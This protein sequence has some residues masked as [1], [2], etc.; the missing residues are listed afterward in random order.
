MK[1]Y[2][3]LFLALLGILGVG[4][5]C[6]SPSSSPVQA[7]VPKAPQNAPKAAEAGQIQGGFTNAFQGELKVVGQI[8]TEEFAKRYPNSAKY[9]DA[10]PWDPTTAQYYDHLQLDPNDP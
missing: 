5:Y 6:K 7:N 10:F 4:Y 9:L 8:S 2:S 1:R 3:L